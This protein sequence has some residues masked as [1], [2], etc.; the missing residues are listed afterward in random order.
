MTSFSLLAMVTLLA[1]GSLLSAQVSKHWGCESFVCL[2]RASDLL[3]LRFVQCLRIW[4]SISYVLSISRQG[5]NPALSAKYS[6]IIVLCRLSNV[7][8]YLFMKP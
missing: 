3:M 7:L 8:D 1:A 2:L 6:I 5:S 4:E